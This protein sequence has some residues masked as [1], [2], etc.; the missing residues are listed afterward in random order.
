M[1]GR[2]QDEKGRREKES[3]KNRRNENKP[4]IVK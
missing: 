3:R 4:D 1:R 2:T